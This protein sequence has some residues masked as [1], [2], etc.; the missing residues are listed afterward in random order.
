M[1]KK[2]NDW[3]LPVGILGAIGLYFY[4]K[5]QPVAAAPAIIPSGAIPMST[6]VNSTDTSA[7]APSVSSTDTVVQT[8]MNTLPP[9][10]RAQALS[11]FPN[12]TAA[13]KNE[14]ADIITNAWGKGVPPTSNQINFWNTWRVTY[15][16]DDGTYIN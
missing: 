2:K 12:M 8:W 9:N 16:V 4:F 10:N 7:P 14:L 6:T 5:Q 1:A 3:L 15:H 11:Q 13:E